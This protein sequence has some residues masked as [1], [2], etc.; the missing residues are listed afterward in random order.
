M[1]EDKHFSTEPGK[2]KLGGLEDN[3]LYKYCHVLRHYRWG[4]DW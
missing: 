3:K 1:Y 2:G 4:L